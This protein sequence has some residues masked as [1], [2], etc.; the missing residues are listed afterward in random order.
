MAIIT[1]LNKQWDAWVK[2]RPKNIQI[3]TVRKER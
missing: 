2:T 1:K 3:L